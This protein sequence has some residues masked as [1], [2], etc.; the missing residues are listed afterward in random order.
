MQL[1][2]RT[3]QLQIEGAL[4]LQQSPNGL[5]VAQPDGG[6]PVQGR[7]AASAASAAACRGSGRAAWVA[8]RLFDLGRRTI[9]S[10]VREVWSQH[11][12]ASMHHMAAGAVSLSSEE[13]F[14]RLGVA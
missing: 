10:H 4:V 3:Q 14:A 13:L 6:R 12:A 8:Q 5:S 1:A 9:V 2:I 7:A 11:A